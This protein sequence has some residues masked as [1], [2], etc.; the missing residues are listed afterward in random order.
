MLGR[1]VGSLTTQSR[2]DAG[3]QVSGAVPACFVKCSCTARP[4]LS[5]DT[6]PIG[7]ILPLDG[8]ARW[9]PVSRCRDGNVSHIGGLQR[10]VGA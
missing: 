7:A 10:F 9:L 3:Y 1:N 5:P 4:V 8:E 2:T 6:L